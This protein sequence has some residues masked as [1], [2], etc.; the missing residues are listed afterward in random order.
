LQALA[1]NDD[2]DDE[3][4]QEEDYVTP[5]LL[6]GESVSSSRAKH[7]DPIDR[8]LAGDV[9]YV[10]YATTTAGAATTAT[11]ATTTRA[12][13]TT[14]A[15]PFTST[16]VRSNTFLFSG[17]FNPLHEGHERL[18]AAVLAQQSPSSSSSPAPTLI[19]ELAIQNVDKPPLD[20][21]TIQQR[22]QQFT[23]AAATSSLGGRGC[24]WPIAITCAPLFLQ[25]ARLFPG[26]C[27]VIGADTAVRLVKPQY[28]NNSR[29]E[30]LVAL[31]ELKHLNCSFVVSGRIVGAA[32]VS[33]SDALADFDLPASL[34]DLFRPIDFRHDLS[35]TDIRSR[36]Q[37]QE[38]AVVCEHK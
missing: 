11:T 37:H 19:F 29:G 6:D 17:S 16:P 30:M 9:G 34:L 20:T 3:V 18:A 33:A 8:L 12:A 1:A 31:A 26:V 22:L 24:P 2:D 21:V 27:F 28:Y 13:T 10:M 25:K 38:E 15:I 32:F 4:D 7:A 35:S 36:Q 5:L 14:S 23:T